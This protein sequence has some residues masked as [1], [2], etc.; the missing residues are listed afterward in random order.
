VKTFGLAVCLFAAALA[1]GCANDATTPSQSPAFQKIDLSLG[2]GAVAALGN[3]LTVNYAGWL[4][5]PTKPDF[6]GLPFDSSTGFAFSLGTGQVISGWDLG[7]IGMNV[8][9]IRRLIIPPSQAYGTSRSGKIP[10]NAAL[11]FDITL[12]NVQ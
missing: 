11:V 6:K 4:Y 3:T 8:G 10:P 1:A 12:T 5:D 9:G 7:L 2:N